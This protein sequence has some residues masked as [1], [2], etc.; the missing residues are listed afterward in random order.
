VSATQAARRASVDLMNVMRLAA[1]LAIA[2]SLAAA[3]VVVEFAEGGLEINLVVYAVIGAVIVV[4]ERSPGT[5]INLESGSTVTLL[6]MFAY[7]MLLLGSPSSALAISL[8]GGLVHSSARD[9]RWPMVVFHLSRL[10]IAIAGAGLVLF[11]MDVRGSVTQ[12]DRIPWRWSIAI[13]LAGVA[14]LMLDTVITE[15][16]QSAGRHVSFVPQLRRGLSL[17][18]TAVGSLLSLAPIWVIGLDSSL[19]LAPLLVITTGLVFASTRRAHERA[20]EAGH[21]VLTGLPNRR[22][23]ADQLLDACG[24][25]GAPTNGALLVMDLNGFKE[26]N[27]RLGHEAGDAVLVA[28]SERLRAS[29]PPNAMPARLGGDEFATLLTWSKGGPVISGLISDLHRRLAEPLTVQGFPLSVGVSIGVARIPEDGRTADELFRA[30]DIAMYRSKRMGTDVELYDVDNGAL[31]TGRLG[32]LSDLGNAIRNN[33]L[34]VDYQPQLSMADGRV[35][36]VEALVRWQHPVHG[37]IAPNDFIGLAEQTD[38][39]GPITDTVLRQATAGLLMTGNREVRLAVNASVRNLQDPEFAQSTLRLLEANGFPPQRLELEVTEGAL[40][41]NAER[42]RATIAELRSAGVCITVDG[43]GTGYASYQ[44]LRALNVDRVKI[45]RDFILRILQDDA[46]RAIVESVVALAHTLG[47][48]V[49]AEGIESNDTWD[50]LAG[51]GCDAAQGFGIALPMSLT[52]LWS[53]MQQWERTV[54]AASRTMTPIEVA[55]TIEP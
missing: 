52:S 51:L 33:E 43:F 7:A 54:V 10:T 42:S 9:H 53:W 44:T 4:C 16:A 5:W 29:L 3:L 38:L 32:I 22:T 30:A 46:D 36:A 31:Q 2:V 26:V 25:F 40:I 28:F 45:D 8:L 35:I 6:P 18:L 48:E 21:D 37:T 19:V 15:I 20:H 41:T 12:F 27:D 34:R 13:V 50:M 24:G 17:R 11:S 1:A 49:I 14:I 55:K 23:F 39:I 47:L